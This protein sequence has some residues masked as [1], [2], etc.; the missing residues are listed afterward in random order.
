MISNAIYEDCKRWNKN[1]SIAWFDYQKAFDSIPHS[2]VEES[3]A[4]VEVNR[5]IVR[6]Y[7]LLLEKW[8]NAS[9][10]NKAGKNAVVAHS[11]TKRIFQGDLLYFSV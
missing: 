1:L 3:I 9:V 8:K 11:D 6:F 7:K 10:K 2:W 4:M 5:K